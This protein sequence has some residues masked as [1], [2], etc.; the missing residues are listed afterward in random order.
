MSD[1]E[2]I[3]LM[4]QKLIDKIDNIIESKSGE[5]YSQDNCDLKAQ[6]NIQVCERYKELEKFIAKGHYTQEDMDQIRKIFRLY[7][8]G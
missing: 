5:I 2:E 6:R 8:P 1:L 3:K 7:L 4:L